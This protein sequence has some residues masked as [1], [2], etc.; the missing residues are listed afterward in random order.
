[1]T[2]DQTTSFIVIRVGAKM[3]LHLNTRVY[4][5][6]FETNLK[7]KG[8]NAGQALGDLTTIRQFVTGNALFA[9]F[10]APWFPVYLFVMIVVGWGAVYLLYSNTARV[11]GF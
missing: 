7:Q 8:V 4:T 6:A 5:A 3:D 1:M 2:A 10:D 9:F 11:K